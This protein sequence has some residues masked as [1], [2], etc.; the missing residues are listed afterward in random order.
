[1]LGRILDAIIWVIVT[2]LSPKTGLNE[3][4]KEID[5]EYNT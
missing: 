4:K 2:L 1:M 5:N 3:I